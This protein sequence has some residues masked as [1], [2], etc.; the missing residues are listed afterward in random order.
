MSDLINLQR[1]AIRTGKEWPAHRLGCDVLASE[2][3]GSRTFAAHRRIS[4]ERI[5]RTVDAAPRGASAHHRTLRN[6]SLSNLERLN[7]N[8]LRR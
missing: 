7:S 2:L 1:A 4:T 3:F 6:E 8:A 5:A